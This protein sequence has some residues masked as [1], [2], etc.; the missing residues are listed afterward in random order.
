MGGETH[1]MR[2][3]V[4]P[5]PAAPLRAGGP[6]RTT[7]GVLEI[8]AIALALSPVG[9]VLLAIPRLVAYHRRFRWSDPGIQPQPG[10]G[11]NGRRGWWTGVREPRR[12]RSPAG[13]GSAAV[14]LPE[15]CEEVDATWRTRPLGAPVSP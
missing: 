13:A 15:L 5:P 14:P 7:G 10:P 11:G 8:L 6:G 9:L 3:K 1:R 4:G 2:G 12:P